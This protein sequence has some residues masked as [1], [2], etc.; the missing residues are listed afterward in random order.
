VVEAERTLRARSG[1]GYR[2]LGRRA[3]TE[4]AR[5]L[6][7]VLSDLASPALYVDFTRFSRGRPRS[8]RAYVA[9]MQAGGLA[10]LLTAHRPLARLLAMAARQWVNV[11]AAFLRRLHADRRALERAFHAPGRVTRVTSVE[12]D[13]SD[14]H[15][16]GKTVIRVRFASGLQVMYKPRELALEA[17][18][19]QLWDWMN[20]RASASHS[21]R[22]RPLQC[23]GARV[24]C[25][26]GYG[27]Q[28]FVRARNGAGRRAATR[29][30]RR[31][32]MVL[33][34]LHAFGAGD[35]H[36][37]NLIAAGEHPVFVDAET[38]FPPAGGAAS[39]SVRDTGLLPNPRVSP[40]GRPYDMSGLGAHRTRPTHL[41]IPRWENV[42]TSRMR[43]RFVTAW[44]APRRNLPRDLSGRTLI[45]NDPQPVVDGFFTMYEFLLQQR[46]LLTSRDGPMTELLR[47]NVR[48]VRRD[49]TDYLLLLNR[50]FGMS[51]LETVDA[52]LRP[53]ERAALRRLDVPR[54]V[55][56][57]NAA[58]VRSRLRRLSR[59]DRDRQIRAIRVSLS[60]RLL[61]HSG[62]FGP[63]PP[64]RSLT[65][66]SEAKR[67]ERTERGYRPP[68]RATDR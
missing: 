29:F 44:T 63:R 18:Y 58:A 21:P 50:S 6:L 41:R 35:A 13:L 27:W 25:R 49:T 57:A 62:D 28:E 8:Y 42:N 4:L 46:G 59:A 55:A 51:W 64:A 10:E 67:A 2:M 7:A 39:R 40:S 12:P 15:D 16:G 3:R 48:L 24:L 45:V 17:G 54:F 65:R 68:P 56:R 38:L 5:P 33:C 23:R 26:P 60:L 9:M 34:L 14:R 32:G 66:R 22:P 47:R 20:A 43:V 11:H 30:Y 61:Y 53:D 31:A 1:V 37:D 52:S 19:S 36:C